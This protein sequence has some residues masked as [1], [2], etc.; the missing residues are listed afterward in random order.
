MRRWETSLILEMI[1]I[2]A[3]LVYSENLSPWEKLSL[4]PLE[5]LYFGKYIKHL[6]ISQK[7]LFG[8]VNVNNPIY[9]YD[10]LSTEKDVDMS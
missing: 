4:Y 10:I 7:T 9:A 3:K 6:V 2:S 5:D 1:G 8:Y